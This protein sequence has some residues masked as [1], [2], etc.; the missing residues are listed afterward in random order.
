MAAV[1]EAAQG[2]VAA[3]EG[4]WAVVMVVEAATAAAMAAVTAPTAVEEEKEG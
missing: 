1:P 2:L 4:A 3:M